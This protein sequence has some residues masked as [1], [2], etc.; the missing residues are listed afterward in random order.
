M[1]KLFNYTIQSLKNS[2][3]IKDI[4]QQGWKPYLVGGCVRDFL[5]CKSPKDIDII[6]VGCEKPDLIQI[7]NKH[8]K[9][10]LVGESFA[11]IKFHYKGEIYDI[12]TPRTEKKVGFGHK[13]FE[14]ISNKD[15]TLEEDL[16]R[17]DI[18][19]NSIAM[20]FDGKYVDPYGGIQDL[21]N[22]VIEITNV[23]AFTDDPLRILRC[24]RFSA[25]FNF[26]IEEKTSQSI[27]KIKNEIRELSQERIVEEWNK[28]LDQ[29]LKEGIDIMKRY[30]NL[31]F[32]YDM[33]S[34]MFPKMKI[35]PHIEITILDNR[36]ILYDL[37]TEMDKKG[38]MVNK[39]KFPSDLVNQIYFL[40]NFKDLNTD[41]VYDM[42]KGKERYHIE[43]GLILKFAEHI[44]MDIKLVKSFLD[45]SN[46][47]FIISGTDLM[48][49]GF[50]DRE[51]EIEKKRLETERFKKEYL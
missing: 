23:S 18:T 41:V 26:E 16:F 33:F 30:V 35:N 20:D 28:T 8:G 46:D 29:S 44:G 19:I 21:K 22:K 13:G 31:L 15:I 34:Q 47:G 42:V 2:D 36:I 45:Y 1:R 48:E 9:S 4:Q 51:I 32:E 37:F 5:M 17:R 27:L 12:S 10:D 43:D 11:V 38:Y 39:L 40:H 24:L 50:K 25:R 14:V 6:V 3:F 49:Q 7:L